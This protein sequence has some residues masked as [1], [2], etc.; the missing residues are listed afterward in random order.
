M[1]GRSNF[2]LIGLICMIQMAVNFFNSAMGFGAMTLYRALAQKAMSRHFQCLKDTI[3]SQLQNMCELLGEKGAG[4]LAP[5]QGSPRVRSHSCASSTKASD[6]N[7]PSTA[8]A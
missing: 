2:C 1:D 5:S 4:S 3:V 8:W 6:S 7:T